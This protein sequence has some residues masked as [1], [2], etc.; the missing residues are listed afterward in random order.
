MIPNGN[1]FLMDSTLDA[2]NR[3]LRKCEMEDWFYGLVQK[4]NIVN[5]RGSIE[6]F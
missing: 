4:T 1:K 6:S 2:E 5:Y 3:V